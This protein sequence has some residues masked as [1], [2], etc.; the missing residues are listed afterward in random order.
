MPNVSLRSAC[1]LCGCFTVSLTF[2]VFTGSYSTYNHYSKKGSNASSAATNRAWLSKSIYH[3]PQS[4]S[5]DLDEPGFW[6]PMQ[7]WYL[8][9][10]WYP[11]KKVNRRKLTRKKGL[12]AVERFHEAASNNAPPF[13]F[14]NKMEKCGS[15]TMRNIIKILSKRNR[16]NFKWIM[17]SNGN[18]KYDHNVA[19]N[20]T[21]SEM[22]PPSLLL[23]HHFWMDFTKHGEEQPLYINVIR[24]PV[25]WVNSK[26]TFRTYGWERRPGCKRNCAIQ[27]KDIDECI[28]KW[29]ECKISPA[30]YILYLC[31]DDCLGLEDKSEMVEITKRKIVKDFLLVGILE[32]FDD[33]LLA[34]EKLLPTYFKGA[35]QVAHSE[36]SLKEQKS[37]NSIN[38]RPMN[39]TNR[40]FLIEGPLKYEMELYNFARTVFNE[41]L[42]SLGIKKLAS[43]SN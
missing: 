26:F 24:H 40:E 42:V 23:V 19:L 9:N 18:Q 39:A 28:A 7:S 14:H 27:M 34:L 33:T 10:A 20:F 38:K 11:P 29:E 4:K 8:K 25:E 43:T 31:G 16:F 3:V 36:E 41:K 35:L 1:V 6:R 2:I 37:T 12:S 21:K 17:L 32:Q 13:V 30:S 22:M 15:T 5:T